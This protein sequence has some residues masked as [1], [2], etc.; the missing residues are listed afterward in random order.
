[1]E[2]W[3]GMAIF[4]L[5][6]ITASVCSGLVLWK[7]EQKAKDDKKERK[8][9]ELEAKALSAGVESL[10]RD[11]LSQGIE[12]YLERKYVPLNTAKVFESMYNSYHNLG[13]NDVITAMYHQFLTL[14]HTQPRE[15]SK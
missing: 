8:Q 12:Y 15:E 6:S 14:P 3:I 13:G 11:R 5:S 9:R 7:Y 1:M 10:L 4:V 2:T